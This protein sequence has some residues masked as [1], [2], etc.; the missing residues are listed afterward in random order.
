MT[1]NNTF[2]MIWYDE[3]AS[4]NEKIKSLLKETKVD[5]FTVI[6]TKNQYQ[7]K[8]QANN[9]WE[10]EKGKNL[11]FSLLIK[12]FYLHA[13]DQ[14]II[15][16]VVCLGILD[17]FSRYSDGFTI[18]WPN[19]IYYNNDK[20]GGILIENTLMGHSIGES[21][22]GI[23]LNI[24]Q[25]KFISNAPNPISLANILNT[26]FDI[27]LMLNQVLQSILK[28]LQMVLEAEDF[29]IIDQKYI[30]N[31]FRNKG[32]HLFKDNEKTFRACIQG[33][34]E[35]GQLIL[36]TETGDINT[37]SFKEVEFIL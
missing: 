28:Y 27:D 37:Y 25:T 6:A 1:E 3:L 10:S 30:E 17:V 20:I 5:E 9:R 8:G 26:Q 35:Y 32:Y 4:T 21:V 19:D 24:N 31:L 11:T 18:K 34:S 7:G 29:N 13:A 12:P 15:S 33:I 22:I 23:G 16:K 14:F 2:H 36:S